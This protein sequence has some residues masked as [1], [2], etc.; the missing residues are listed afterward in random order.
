MGVHHVCDAGV[1]VAGHQVHA[2]GRG[3]VRAAQDGVD[4]AY[5]GGLPDARAGAAPRRF[6]KGVELYLEASTACLAV[7]LEL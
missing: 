7:L 3:R 6:S 2:P 4:I 1:V 5:G